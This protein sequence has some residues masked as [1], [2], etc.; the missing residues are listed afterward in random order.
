MTTGAAIKH[1]FASAVRQWR[2]HLGISQEALAERAG[3]HR[4]YVSDVE[5]GAR[6][7][8]LESISKLA[9]ALDVSI[10]TL[11]PTTDAVPPAIPKATSGALV[12]I[13]LVEDN[14]DD[15]ELTL[16]AFKRARFSNVVHVVHDG[17]EALDYVFSQGDYVQHRRN[18]HTRVI[19]MDLSL[20]KMNGLEVLRRIKGDKST[21]NIPV[22]I[23]TG[24]LRSEDVDECRRLGADS[25]IIKPLDFH[26]LSQVTPSLNLDWSLVK[27]TAPGGDQAHSPTSR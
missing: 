3:L 6:N 11:F 24:S 5:R 14:L 19:L 7:L 16:R 17:A 2:R 22:V 12:E 10:S 20:P 15:V 4:T 21:R 8:S 1:K 25:Y 13:L 23:L 9:R 26:R 27:P 18:G